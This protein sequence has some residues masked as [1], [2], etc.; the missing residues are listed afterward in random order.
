M[1]PEMLE[2]PSVSI[3]RIP[4]AT[5]AS[6]VLECIPLSIRDNESSVLV[7]SAILLISSSSRYRP[8]IIAP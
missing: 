4:G 7:A 6:R 5:P 8:M 3:V 2:N 1:L